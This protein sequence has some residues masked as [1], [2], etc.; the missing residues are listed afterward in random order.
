MKNN[1]LIPLDLQFF[2]EER[3]ASRRG[4]EI[5]ERLTAIAAEINTV[6]TD[7]E[8]SALETEAEN[9]QTER[10][11][12]LELNQRRAALRNSVAEG[13][14]TGGGNTPSVLSRLNMSGGNEDAAD[15]DRFAT[16]EYR[17]AFMNHVLRGTA[18]PT[19]Y[20]MEG[21]THTTDVGSVIPTPTLNRIIEEM[22]NSGMILPLV[23]R[24]AHQGG[25]RIPTSSVKPIATWVAEGAGSPRQKK[26]TGEIVFAYH[27]LRCAVAVTLEVETM[28]L[29]IFE[30]HLIS[31]VVEA[32]VMAIEDAII[33]GT[34]VGQPRG[35]LTTAPK[36][37]QLIETQS[38]S[39]DD[40]I[41][42]ESALPTQYERNTKWCMTKTTFMKYATLRDDNGQ[43][44]GQTN[45]GGAANKPERTLMG[46]EVVLCDYL[47]SYDVNLPAGTPFM[48]LF[49]FKDYILNTNLNMGV[50][51]FRDNDTDDMVSVAVTLVD[52]QAVD[53]GSLVV[54]SKR[55]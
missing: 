23:T 20:R 39:Y 37:G 3:A 54:V 19:Q 16:M 30:A 27:K 24:T 49:N 28:A 26:P 38:V 17:R 48:F 35:I 15:D 46:R 45:R 42:V 29:A 53:N 18:I 7:A 21:T 32:M 10:R 50:R 25:L 41:E 55:L 33:N 52:G 1:S 2:N 11:G 12:L 34:G 9:L 47:P 51:R 44:I 8:M 36:A 31:N 13:R 6:T 40:L 14:G 43:P 4:Q 22:E 5:E